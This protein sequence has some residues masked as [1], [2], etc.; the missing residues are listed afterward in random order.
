MTG[1][2]DVVVVSQAQDGIYPYET[3]PAH[4]EYYHAE[5]RQKSLRS[6]GGLRG[7]VTID[8][9][10]DA[11]FFYLCDDSGS[12]D[13]VVCFWC[14]G[15]LHNWRESDDPWEEHTRLVSDRFSLSVLCY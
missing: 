3:Q 14:S 4:I 13:R 5:A 6:Y 10:S 8:S 15:G 12:G 11:G 7:R 2:T 1:Y 9:L